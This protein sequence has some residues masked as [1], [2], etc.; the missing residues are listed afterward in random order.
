MNYK[1]P[2]VF[3]ATPHADRKNYCLEQYA[4]VIKSLTYPNKVVMMADNSDT[5]KNSKLLTK[6]G[7]KNVHI[8]PK[9]KSSQQYICE[10]HNALRSAFLRSDAHI[11]F[12]LESD[13]IPPP[14]IIERLL[15][16]RKRVVGAPYFI[17]EGEDS[18]LIVQDMEEFFLDMRLTK[19]MDDGTDFMFMDG[20]LKKVHTVG[21]G[22]IMIDRP[23]MEKIP[24]RWEKGID[25]HP[26]SFFAHDCHTLD[27][28]IW[29]DTSILCEHNNS[30]WSK[31]SE[32]AS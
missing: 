27:I 20:K 8:R 25:A 17:G 10:S 7:F 24:F 15:A 1:K 31:Y 9:R 3:I 26:D 19:R 21:L 13:I 30:G 28:P 22:C 5:T 4:E 23:T 29:C 32:A 16:T 11:F 12:H 18:H 2:K 6:M 14:D